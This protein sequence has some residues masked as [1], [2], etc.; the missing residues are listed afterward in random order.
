MDVSGDRG[1]EH[2]VT[3]FTV[4]SLYVHC[5][6]TVLVHSCVHRYYSATIIRMSGV[7]SD[8]AAV[9]MVTEALNF[10]FNVCSYCVFTVYAHCVFTG[11]TAPPPSGCP[12]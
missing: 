5:V 2:P 4:C 8:E 6:F 11:T 9:C 7:K 3:M 1:N 12:G 10:L